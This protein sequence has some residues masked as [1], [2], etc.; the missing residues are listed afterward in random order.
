SVFSPHNSSLNKGLASSVQLVANRVYYNLQWHATNPCLPDF[1]ALGARI[2][3]LGNRAAQPAIIPHL[4]VVMLDVFSKTS[5]QT[6]GYL[7]P[8]IGSSTKTGFHQ[9]SQPDSNDH[10]Q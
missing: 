4:R 9:P 10:P 3:K 5:R 1:R 7:H 6:F 8:S 2:R